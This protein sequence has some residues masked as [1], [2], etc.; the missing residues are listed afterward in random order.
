[1]AAPA[2]RVKKSKMLSLDVPSRSRSGR[3]LIDLK[4]L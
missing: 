3:H 2:T 4:G 1:V